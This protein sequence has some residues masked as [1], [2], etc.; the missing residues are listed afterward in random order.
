MTISISY[1]VDSEIRY[2]RRDMLGRIKLSLWIR[3]NLSVGTAAIDTNSVDDI[4]K[5][6]SS[7]MLIRI[8]GL[9][10]ETESNKK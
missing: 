4:Y 2:F 6:E 5:L 7:Y 9:V 3:V 1:K 8:L 10:L